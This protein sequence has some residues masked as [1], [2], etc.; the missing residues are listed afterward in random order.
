[1]AFETE[2]V[3]APDDE[4]AGADDEGSARKHGECRYLG[5]DPVAEGKSKQHRRVVERRDHRD[6]GIAVAFGEEHLAEAAE[7]AGTDEEPGLSGGRPGPA[8]GE[9]DEGE[10]RRDQREVEDDGRR[11]LGPDE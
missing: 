7:E 1:A 9:G 2:A 10:E 3:L 6:V 11:R 8:E 5:E 4:E